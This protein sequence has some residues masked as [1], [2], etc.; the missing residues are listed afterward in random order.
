MDNNFSKNRISKMDNI[1][2]YILPVIVSAGDYIAII[3]AEAIAFY[4]CNFFIPEG[5]HMDI[6]K[7]YFYLWVPAVFIFFLFYADTHKRVVPYW[8]KIKDIFCANFYSII[9]AIFILYLIHEDITKISRLYVV[10]LFIFSLVFLYGIRQILIYI[11]NRLDILKEPV[12]FIGGGEV[13]EAVIKFYDNNSC[14]GIKVVGII[15]DDFSSEYLKQR[16]PLFKGIDK[17]AEYIKKCGVKTV[18]I[19]KT[20]LD[21]NSLKELLTNIQ[22][23]VRNVA[24]IPNIIGTPIANLDVRRIYREDIVLLNIKNNLAYMRNRIAKRIFDI[25]MGLIICIPAVPILI[26]CYFWVKFDSKG[27]VFFN[28]KRIGK[29]GK[30]FTCYKFRSMYMNS[31]EILADYLAKNPEAKAEW[32]EFQKLHDFDPRVTKAG[33]IMRKTSLD[34]LPQLLNVLKGEMSLVGPRP[35]LPREIG[36][37]GE[38]YKIIIST[39]PGITGFW[40]VNGRSEVTFEG[41][42]KMDNWYIYNWSI[43]IDMVLLFKTI[44]AVFFS[45]GA[46]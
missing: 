23:L 30:E 12:I 13:T 37:M 29:D 35:Y 8:E 9:A 10:L 6:P 41:R 43:W 21:R 27:P 19:A 22:F 4:L 16:Y 14:F 2:A 1:A 18:I 7:S 36:K 28:A 25:I 45:K 17:S 11:C 46:V 39:V 24:F 3:L 44:K 20:R 15:D 42:L 32:D 26:L 38:Y 5:F 40:Q 34:E 31:D 33:R